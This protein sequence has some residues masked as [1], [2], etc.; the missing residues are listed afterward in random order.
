[1]G[2]VKFAVIG[3]CH[4]SKRG[5]YSTRDCLGARNQLKRIIDTMNTY[6]LDFVLSLGDMGD[7][8]DISETPEMLEVYAG[9]VNPVKFTIGNHDLCTRNDEEHAKFVGMPAPFYDYEI[10]N[11]KLVVLNAFEQSRYSPADSENRKVYEK[12]VEENFEGSLPAFLAAFSK[13]K[14]L[15]DDEVAQLRK[16]IDEYEEG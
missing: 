9:S 16:M 4:H 12:F 15:S 10:K 7:G 3:D 2:K 6:E 14:K 1:M 5:N 11:Y 8:F 13:R